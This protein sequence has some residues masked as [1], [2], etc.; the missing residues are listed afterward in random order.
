MFFIK[1]VKNQL[2]RFVNDPLIS[3]IRRF[4]TSRENR[5]IPKLPFLFVSPVCQRER[6]SVTPPF[7]PDLFLMSHCW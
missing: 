6:S 2:F 4:R 7:N 3:T 1:D 5:E